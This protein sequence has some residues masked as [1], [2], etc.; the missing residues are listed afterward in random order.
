MMIEYV[1]IMCQKMIRIFEL[2]LL[3]II[4]FSSLSN[5][6]VATSSPYYYYYYDLFISSNDF[7]FVPSG[8]YIFDA[9]LENIRCRI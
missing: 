6:V 4:A 7:R 3:I 2:S 8:S 5:K 1:Y 9:R